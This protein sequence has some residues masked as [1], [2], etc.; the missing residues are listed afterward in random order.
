MLE[1]SGPAD[2]IDAIE[3]SLFTAGVITQRIDTGDEVFLHHP[4]LLK[5]LT[6]TQVRAGLLALVIDVRETDQLIARVQDKREAIEV[7]N[8]AGMIAAVHQML[9]STGILHDSERA[10]L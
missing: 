8:R 4:A 1:L 6:D 9:H 7:S 3:R 5:I 2:A 10:G